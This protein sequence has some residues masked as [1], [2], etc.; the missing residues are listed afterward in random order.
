MSSRLRQVGL[1]FLSEMRN[2]VTDES[3]EARRTDIVEVQAVTKEQVRF[4]VKVVPQIDE[5][6]ILL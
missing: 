4:F 6:D 5:F 3:A 2:F 1:R